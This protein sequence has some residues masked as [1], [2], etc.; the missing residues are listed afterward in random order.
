MNPPELPQ[1]GN[2]PVVLVQQNN[3]YFCV[4]QEHENGQRKVLER[5]ELVRLVC[6]VRKSHV[7]GLKIDFKGE[8]PTY[9]LSIEAVRMGY[10]FHKKNSE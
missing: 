10:L 4:G 5:F 7:G 2:Q 8:K 3:P 1:V 9:H 6:F